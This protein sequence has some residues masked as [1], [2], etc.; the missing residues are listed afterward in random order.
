[1]QLAPYSYRVDPLVP[2]FPDDRAVLFYDGVCYLCSGF[3]RFVIRKDRTGRIR[4]CQVQSALGQAIYQ[5]YG[6]DPKEFDS[7]LILS[8]GRIFLK[9]DGFC[10]C[11]RILGGFWGWMGFLRFCPRPLRDRVYE[12]VARNRYRWFGRREA[13]EI[14]PAADSGRYLA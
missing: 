5:H 8:R 2:P 3:G 11:M 9:S 1:M 4:L 14:P 7:F 6:L 12:L 13:C 10:E